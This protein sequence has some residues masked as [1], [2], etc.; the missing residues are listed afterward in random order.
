MLT[1]LNKAM[2]SNEHTRFATLVLA[3]VTHRDGEVMLRLTSA[4]HPHR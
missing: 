4:G 1:L 3:S 2:L